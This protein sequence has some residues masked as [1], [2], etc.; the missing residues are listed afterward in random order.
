[1]KI[2]SFNVR[3]L[4][5]GAKRRVIK[6]RVIQNQ[7][8]VLFIQ[9]SKLQHVDKRICSQI[10][11][12]SSFDWRS[13]PAINRGG[14]LVCIWNPTTFTLGDCVIGTGF[15][16]LIGVWNNTQQHCVLV[17]VYSACDMIG[18]RALWS[19][20]QQW[21]NS[22]Q[23]VTWC[24]AGDFN[25]V[26]A[27]EERRG[28]TWGL[29]SQR[30]EIQEFNAFIAG[31]ELLDLP[32]AGRKFTWCRPNNQAKSRIDRFLVSHDWCSLWPHCSQLVLQ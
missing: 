30:V 20:L 1:M 11:G 17:N 9:E 18:K 27:T 21:R 15:L 25:A 12:D 24:L 26:R 31:M 22:C 6:E 2:M 7:V 3:G 28:I 13:I 4:G 19:E 16:G 8:E 5:E 23:I 32:L 10:W 29:N 14:G